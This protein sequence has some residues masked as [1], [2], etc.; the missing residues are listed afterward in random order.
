MVCL[1]WSKI[2]DIDTLEEHHYDGQVLS[3]FNLY[4]FFE[5]NQTRIGLA[6]GLK[7]IKMP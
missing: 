6:Y 3:L 1:Y 5:F 4:G 2:N 7:L